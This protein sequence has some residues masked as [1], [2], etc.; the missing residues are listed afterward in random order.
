MADEDEVKDV[1]IGGHTY[2]AV[3]STA[4]SLE[5]N[6][7]EHQTEEGFSVADNAS[8]T[9]PKF[10]FTLKL[11]KSLSNGENEY[12][13]LK[14]LFEKLTPFTLSCEFGY[15]ENMIIKT[16]TPTQGK[17]KNVIEADITISQ[18]RTG[19]SQ[20][21]TVALPVSSSKENMAGGTT[22]QG[23]T[24]E[25]TTEAA[26]KGPTYLDGCI[27]LTKTVLGNKTATGG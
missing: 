15:Y 20:T 1:I 6:V 5:A 17:G 8:I 16:L 19:K 21:T 4:L 22:A 25:Y 9:A 26:E 27:N 12:A 2:E 7:P 10:T 11:F 24:T 14:T 13:T 18:I 3:L 23:V